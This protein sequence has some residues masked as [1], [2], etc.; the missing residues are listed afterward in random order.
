MPIFTNLRAP[1]D[2]FSPTLLF[3]FLRRNKGTEGMVI[4]L[5]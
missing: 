2:D 1:R 4:L 3:R 5:I